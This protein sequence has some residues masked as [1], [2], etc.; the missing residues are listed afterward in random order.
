RVMHGPRLFFFSSRRRHTRSK[1]DWSS[2]V[3]SSDLRQIDFLDKLSNRHRALR[4]E[5]ATV[6]RSENLINK[7]LYTPHGAVLIA[8]RHVQ[9][10]ADQLPLDC[11]VSLEN[12]IA[13]PHKPTLPFVEYVAFLFPHHFPL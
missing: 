6:D 12:V 2:D 9:L 4:I 1:R 10:L 3:C 8:V 5:Q 11:A 7:R 13:I